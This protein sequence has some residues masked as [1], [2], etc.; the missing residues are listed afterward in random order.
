MIQIHGISEYSAVSRCTAKI[1]GGNKMYYYRVLCIETN[2]L[3]E[4]VFIEKEL[5]NEYAKRL[6]AL[7]SFHFTVWE[8]IYLEK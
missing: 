6:Q 3:S 2:V 5:A 1:A 4:R 8:V 7:S